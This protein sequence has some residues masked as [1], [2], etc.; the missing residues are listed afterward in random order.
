MKWTHGYYAK[1]A[2]ALRERAAALG[3]RWTAADVERALWA[4]AGGK[5]KARAMA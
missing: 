4:H 3:G 5:A 1:Y 2:A